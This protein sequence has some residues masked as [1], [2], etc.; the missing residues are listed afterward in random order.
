[1]FD[2]IM[3]GLEMMSTAAGCTG[4]EYVGTIVYWNGGGARESGAFVMRVPFK[5]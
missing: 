1:M 5:G 3:S 2:I 4:F